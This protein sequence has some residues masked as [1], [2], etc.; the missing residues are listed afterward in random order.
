MKKI[1]LIAAAL[2]ILGQAA[3]VLAVQT[4][5]AG[6]WQRLALPDGSLQYWG[7]DDYACSGNHC[8]I[9]WYGSQDT[10]DFVGT[11]CDDPG[12]CI[13]IPVYSKQGWDCDEIYLFED[14]VCLAE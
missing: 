6:T 8:E 12:S 3:S 5:S 10:R 2:L 13:S 9:Y 4:E 14:F 1:L 7:N 11:P